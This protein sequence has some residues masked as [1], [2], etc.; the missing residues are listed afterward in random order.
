MRY[1]EKAFIFSLSLKFL[2]CFLFDK[3]GNKDSVIN[4]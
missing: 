4:I 2:D 1:G 3:W